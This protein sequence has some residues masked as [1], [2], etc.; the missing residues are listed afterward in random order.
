MSRISKSIEI[1]SVCQGL[2][3]SENECKLM[4][5]EFLGGDEN[6]YEMRRWL[7]NFVNILKTSELFP[8]LKK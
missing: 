4:G 2:G 5:M 3:G 8:F 6:V 7:H 1:E